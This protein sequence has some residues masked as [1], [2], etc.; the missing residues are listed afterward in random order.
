MNKQLMILEKREALL[1]L[2]SLTA[3]LCVLFGLVYWILYHPGRELE[4]GA[5]E[6]VAIL[7]FW[8]FLVAFAGLRSG[9]ALKE[10]D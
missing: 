1:G 9:F 4:S 5:G 2:V 6:A 10:R 7:V 3:G 8:L